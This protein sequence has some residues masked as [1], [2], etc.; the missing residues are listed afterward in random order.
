MT[1]PLWGSLSLASDLFEENKARDSSNQA[2][3]VISAAT[4]RNNYRGEP[5]NME[6][7]SWKELSTQESV[8]R[9]PEALSKWD[10]PHPGSPVPYLR[11]GDS[12]GPRLTTV[13]RTQGAP[14]LS[15]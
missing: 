7:P 4:R 9:G 13:K 8:G 2:V 15:L 14:F 3:S 11:L 12:K 10:N 5:E 1:F 6:A